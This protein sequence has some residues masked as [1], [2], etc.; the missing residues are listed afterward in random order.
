MPISNQMMETGFDVVTVMYFRYIM[1]NMIRNGSTLWRS[2]LIVH[3]EDKLGITG[4]INKSG[5]VESSAGN[6]LTMHK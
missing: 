6:L 4:Q 2:K 3:L 5:K 1:T